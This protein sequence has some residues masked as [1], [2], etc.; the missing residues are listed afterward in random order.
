MALRSASRTAERPPGAP[1]GAVKTSERTPKGSVGA[2]V[3]VAGGLCARRS[4][5]RRTSSEDWFVEGWA[6]A[7]ITESKLENVPFVRT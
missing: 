1:G 2:L 7:P 4:S 6:A 5:A 3:D